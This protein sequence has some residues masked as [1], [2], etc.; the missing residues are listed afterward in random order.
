M[1]PMQL[2]I[3]LYLLF[4]IGSQLTTPTSASFQDVTTIMG[5]LSVHDDFEHQQGEKELPFQSENQL[6]AAEA[7]DDEV[8][9][10]ENH[11]QEEKN[12]GEVPEKG[13]QDLKSDLQVHQEEKQSTIEEEESPEGKEQD[14]V[15]SKE[16]PNLST[17]I[18]GSQEKKDIKPEAEQAL[19]SEGQ[20]DAKLDSDKAIIESDVQKSDPPE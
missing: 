6:K 4:L 2:L 9:K 13:E 20:D 16:P 19:K 3:L 1:K 10:D 5:T 12:F 7:V 17:D 14:Q 15:N 8:V 18:T 11:E